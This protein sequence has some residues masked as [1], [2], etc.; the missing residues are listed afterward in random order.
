MDKKHGPAR[1]KRQGEEEEE[2][3][4]E[5]EQEQEE[6]ESESE[7]GQKKMEE[8]ERKEVEEAFAAGKR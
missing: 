8:I 6:Q 5:Q 2:E 7:M 1:G 3:E 4:K